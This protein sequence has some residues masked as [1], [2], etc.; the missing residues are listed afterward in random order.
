MDADGDIDLLVGHY[1]DRIWYY[2]NTAG[3]GTPSVFAPY[4]VL[5][6]NPF[7]GSGYITNP[8]AVDWDGDGD[9]DLIVGS[10]S[11]GVRVF[12]NNGDPTSPSFS[13]GSY[14]VLIPSGVSYPCPVHVDWENDGDWDLLVGY[15]DGT[16]HLY[17]NDNGTLTDQGTLSTTS[18]VLDVGMYAAPEVVDWDNDGDWDLVVGEYYGPVYLFR[19]GPPVS[20]NLAGTISG[21]TLTLVWDE[22]PG[23]AFY[24]I[25]GA[26]NH[27]YFVPGLTMP[28]QYRRG[29]VLAG[30]T[31]WSNPN[32][33]GDPDHNWTYQIIA[34]NASLQDISRSNRF[35][36]YDFST[37]TGP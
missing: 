3:P 32:G 1:Y 23:A 30:T 13:S 14:Q 20:V 2:E 6:N 24:W 22:V 15:Y 9:L 11:Y 33:V 16:V 5:L 37:S 12:W 35:G 17:E 36:E 31:T 34:M 25:Y 19:N 7:G 29:D 21:G 18:G 8:T 10:S 26:D 4:V 28:W 27:V